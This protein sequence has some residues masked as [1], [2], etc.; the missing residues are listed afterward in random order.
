MDVMYIHGKFQQ[1]T[2]S[3]TNVTLSYTAEIKNTQTLDRIER[4]GQTR[5]MTAFGFKFFGALHI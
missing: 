3:K 4:M 2:N 1:I 5:L